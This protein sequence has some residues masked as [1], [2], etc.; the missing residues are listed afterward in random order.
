MCTS[1]MYV[2]TRCNV[3]FFIFSITYFFQFFNFSFF[4]FFP[5]KPPQTLLTRNETTPEVVF[6]DQIVQHHASDDFDA[7]RVFQL[8]A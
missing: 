3:S 1:T 8:S 7:F 4:H 2:Y 6:I 5:I